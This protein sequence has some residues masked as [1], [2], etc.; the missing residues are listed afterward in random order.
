MK[1][2]KHDRKKAFVL[3]FMYA[4]KSAGRFVSL[5]YPVTGKSV[6]KFAEKLDEWTTKKTRAYF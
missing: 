1:G 2:C 3:N 4:A 6:I 5:L